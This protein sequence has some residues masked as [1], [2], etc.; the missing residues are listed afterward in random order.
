MGHYIRSLGRVDRPFLLRSDN[1]LVFTFP[2]Y[3]RMVRSH[4]IRQG[5]ITP[6]CRSRTG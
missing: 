5:F 2:A 6:H 1:G 3:A 4:G